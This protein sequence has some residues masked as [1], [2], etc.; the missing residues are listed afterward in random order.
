MPMNKK[1]V[2]LERRSK[3]AKLYLEGMDQID[4]GIALGFSQSQVSRDL[5]A[6]RKQWQES[7]HDDT[8]EMIAI[9]LKKID[10]LERVAW[11]AWNKSIEDTRKKKAAQRTGGPGG[12]MK[13]KQEE[14]VIMLGNPAYLRQI[15]ACI[16]R[17]CE[18]L[19]LD[20][21]KRI[22]HDFEGIPGLDINA[23]G[24][25]I[26]DEEIVTSEEEMVQKYG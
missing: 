3:V 17:R 10:N 20:A 5:K 19:G 18:L 15:E 26:D 21:P 6:L 9:E 25:V 1:E 13:M 16:K 7:A 11:R 12:E 22:N 8:G 24:H 2:I 4:I 23:D 14:E